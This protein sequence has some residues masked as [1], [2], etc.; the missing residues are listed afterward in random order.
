VQAPAFGKGEVF[1]VKAVLECVGVA[2]LG[3]RLMALGTSLA[4][5]EAAQLVAAALSFYRLFG[6]NDSA[7][8][9]GHV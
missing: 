9:C 4:Q 8:S 1:G 7:L 5:H 3:Q 2:G 6:W